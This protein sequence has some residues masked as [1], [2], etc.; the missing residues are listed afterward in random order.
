MFGWLQ[1]L[2]QA[3][4]SL[5][6][7]VFGEA[8]PRRC[9]KL[10]FESVRAEYRGQEGM[11][12]CR[13]DTKAAEVAQQ[14]ERKF[15][16]NPR[17]FTM[18]DAL[19]YERVTGRLIPCE[20]LKRKVLTTRGRYRRLVSPEDFQGYMETCP[21]NPL[22]AGE[23][24]IQAD[25]DD[26]LGRMQWV[27]VL[28]P[29][30]EEMRSRISRRVVEVLVVTVIALAYLAW[31]V[32]HPWHQPT[33][34]VDQKGG[35]SPLLV[36]LFLGLIGGMVSVQQRIQTAPTD[37]DAIRNVMSLFNGMLSIYLSPVIGAIS[38]CLFYLLLIGG[39]VKGDL[40]PELATS[41]S[42][43]DRSVLD[44]RPFLA[45][46]GPVSGIAYAKLMI[47]SFL[48]G[49]AE[50]LVPDALTRLVTAVQSP[51]GQPPRPVVEVPSPGRGQPGTSRSPD[52][53]ESQ[54]KQGE[55]PK[56]VAP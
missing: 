54:P 10:Y 7:W 11:P 18:T 23:S 13:T 1:N 43:G 56:V 31:F 32:Y 30:R 24:A 16:E 22:E 44:L 33:G 8:I 40:F 19:L 49:F 5:R 36:A 41:A 15:D 39:Y 42:A 27:Y 21:P 12:G 6:H 9:I 28:S 2:P 48:A 45:A 4:E 29:F 20:S 35:V 51:E 46:S 34:S 14:I 47:W 38:A 52:A 25:L 3:F 26:L 17:S 55:P 50:R 53:A 37:S